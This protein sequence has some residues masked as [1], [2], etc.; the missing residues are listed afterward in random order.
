LF[1]LDNS[2]DPA[3]AAPRPPACCAP[4]G[5]GGSPLVKAFVAAL[6]R[7]TGAPARSGRLTESSPSS[8]AR[9]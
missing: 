4:P 6:A 7:G 1:D 9:A 8:P 5:L 3:A 2:T